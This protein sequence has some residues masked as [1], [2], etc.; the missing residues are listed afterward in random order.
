MKCK[1]IHMTIWLR[2][3]GYRLHCAKT[4]TFGQRRPLPNGNRRWQVWAKVQW[5]TGGNRECGRRP[6][7]PWDN[8]GRCSL[9]L[10]RIAYC[11][12]HRGLKQGRTS[13]PCPQACPP[14]G[15]ITGASACENWLQNPRQLSGCSQSLTLSCSTWNWWETAKFRHLAPQS[16]AVCPSALQGMVSTAI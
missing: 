7:M 15:D 13:D 3:Y 10:V 6:L 16:L 4:E 11:L 12:C 8:R 9:V 14:E 2:P 1:I 5:S